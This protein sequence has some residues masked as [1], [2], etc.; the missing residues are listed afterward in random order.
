M[1]RHTSMV[2]RREEGCNAIARENELGWAYLPRTPDLDAGATVEGGG[3]SFGSS[4][5]PL[6]TKL[7]GDAESGEVVSRN[8]EGCIRT[9]SA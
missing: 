6:N 8:I 3:T 2:C 4:M 7:D 1:A 5:V 9:F